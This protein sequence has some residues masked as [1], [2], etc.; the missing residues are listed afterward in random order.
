MHW[1][2]QCQA[3]WQS[4]KF[5]TNHESN[6]CRPSLC[7]QSKPLSHRFVSVAWKKQYMTLSRRISPPATEPVILCLFKLNIKARHKIRELLNAN[8]WSIH[9]IAFY[10]DWSWNIFTLHNF[11]SMLIEQLIDLEKV[12]TENLKFRTDLRDQV[13]DGWSVTQWM[14]VYKGRLLK[15]SSNQ[16]SKL[17]LSTLVTTW[18]SNISFHLLQIWLETLVAINSESRLTSFPS[19]CSLPSEVAVLFNSNLRRLPFLGQVVDLD[20]RIQFGRGHAVLF[21][22]HIFTQRPMTDRKI[23][24]STFA[25]FQLLE[26]TGRSRRLWSTIAHFHP[27]SPSVI[28]LSLAGTPPSSSHHQPLRLLSHSPPVSLA[29]EGHL[30]TRLT[31]IQTWLTLQ[32][33]DP[34]AVHRVPLWKVLHSHAREGEGWKVEEMQRQMDNNIVDY[35]NIVDWTII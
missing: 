17:V 22:C 26:P 32:G 11:C 21:P 13:M 18:L 19:L 8:L 7:N 27:F 34:R 12:R 23:E 6:P 30:G 15:K 10:I 1:R 14:I 31:L 4:G 33:G 28:T 5:S 35:N 29:L 16:K 25:S 20:H 24:W 9:F 3:K 2:A